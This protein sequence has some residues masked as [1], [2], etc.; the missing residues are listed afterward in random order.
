MRHSASM[1][2]LTPYVVIELGRLWH[3]WWSGAL[4]TNP[5]VEQMLTYYQSDLLEHLFQWNLI[6]NVSFF[7]KD[8]IIENVVCQMSAILFNGQ[9][10]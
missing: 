6:Q 8:D 5:S 10:I 4:R 7:I 2:L 9:S 1:S 3:M